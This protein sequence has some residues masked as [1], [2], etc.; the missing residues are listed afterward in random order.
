MFPRP[1]RK[2]LGALSILLA[3]LLGGCGDNE[4]PGTTPLDTTAPR[5]T[6]V[7]PAPGESDVPVTTVLEVTFSEPIDLD[8]VT[9]ESIRLFDRIDPATPLP[10]ARTLRK[11]AGGD[12]ITFTPAEPLAY[13]FSYWA[14]V[15]SSLT[16]LAGN[17]MAAHYSW[18]FST[19]SEPAPPVEFPL[20]QGNAW[21][22]TSESSATVWTASGVSTSTFEGLR[23]LY[24]EEPAFW[25]GRNGWLLRSYTLD[26]TLT[27][28]SALRSE[29]FYLAQ[30]H[31]GLYRASTKYDQGAWMN[32]AQYYELEF[33]DSAFL[34][35]GGPAHSDGSTLSAESVTVPAGDFETI[36]IE[37]D[38]SSTGPYASEDIFETRREYFADGVGLVAATWD[39]TFDDNDPSGIDISTDGFASL[40]E[41]MNG[42]SLPYLA[43]EFE[44]NDS[45]GH[46]LAQTM[47]QTSIISGQVHIDDAFTEV[48]EEDVACIYTLCIKPNIDENY[49]M[50]D[51]YRIEITTAGQY[52][53]DLVYDYYDATN[54]SWNDLDLYFF[55]ELDASN[56][57][58]MARADA[59]V[60]TPEWMILLHLDVGIYYA[61]VQAWNTPHEPVGYT[62]ALRPQPVYV[63]PPGTRS[64][65]RHGAN[66]L[67]SGGK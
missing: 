49:Y 47:P 18:T 20:A 23:V 46:G 34:I 21:L 27:T 41:A 11:A 59:D 28:E 57:G 44:P 67:A 38:Y 63:T 50:Q 7:S 13:D 1:V 65:E 12:Q 31:L 35:A 37:H 60:N 30:D 61:A 14:L 26:Q 51:W 42:P 17:T 19:E 62:L 36:R 39:Y 9:E 3:S 10:I 33:D 56:I 53:L 6:A 29:Y 2:A 45:P 55:R 48:L 64:P 16:D 25:E 22:Y 24:V 4:E 43:A 52:R 8:S 58:F 66:Y 5:V 15:D 40:A 32:V 54:D